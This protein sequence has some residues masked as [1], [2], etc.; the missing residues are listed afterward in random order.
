MPLFF[1]FFL[2]LLLLA[3]RRTERGQK[4]N[5]AL[6]QLVPNHFACQTLAVESK[7]QKKT[8]DAYATLERRGR[9]AGREKDG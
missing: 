8:Q 6:S 2:L 3:L 7:P 4:A 1:W 5:E 9:T